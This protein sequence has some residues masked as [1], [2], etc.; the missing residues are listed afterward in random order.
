MGDNGISFNRYSYPI[1][2][3]RPQLDPGNKPAQTP[4]DAGDAP[5]FSQM[6]RQQLEQQGSGLTFSKHAATRVEQRSIDLD[7]SSI[8]RL[9]QGVRIAEQKGLDDALILI[10]RTAFLV[11]VKNS[12]VIT[13]VNGEELTG[14]VFTNIDGTVI[15]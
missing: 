1:V 13:T 14:N 7:S 12:T 6:L 10:D 3:G 15:I 9:D 4:R 2:T 11:S 8:A 5:S